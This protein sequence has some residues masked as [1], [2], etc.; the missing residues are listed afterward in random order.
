MT[1]KAIAVKSCMQ[2]SD[3]THVEYKISGSGIWTGI[4]GSDRD[5]CGNEIVADNEYYIYIAGD[6]VPFMDRLIMFILLF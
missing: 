2:N 3:I 1:T 5:D 4:Y 6:T